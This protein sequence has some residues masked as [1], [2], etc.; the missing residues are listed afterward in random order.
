VADG[1]SSTGEGVRPG[2]GIGGTRGVEGG[3]VVTGRNVGR[4]P[5]FGV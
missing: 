4:T 5:G 2:T 1:E 3:G